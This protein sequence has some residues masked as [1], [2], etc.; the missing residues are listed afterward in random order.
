M[1][2][3]SLLVVASLRLSFFDVYG[4]TADNDRLL[5]RIH[6][7]H[8]DNYNV[9]WLCRA[10]VRDITLEISEMFVSYLISVKPFK[11]SFDDYTRLM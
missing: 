7:N 4:P 8:K 10:R 1:I 3:L 9:I 6:V 5:L 11:L 2:L